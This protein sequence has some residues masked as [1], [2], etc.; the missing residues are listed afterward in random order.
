MLFN[1]HSFCVLY[2]ASLCSFLPRIS[3]TICHT[4]SDSRSFLI[5]ILPCCLSLSLLFQLHFLP[6]SPSITFY[7]LHL[8]SSITFA[9]HISYVLCRYIF[10]VFFCLLYLSPLV[11]I[12]LRTSL[13]L[14]HL[15][16]LLSFSIS[17]LLPALS[18][19]L[20]V[21][22]QLIP[23]SH[24]IHFSSSV[25][26][27]SMCTRS[28]WLSTLRCSPSLSHFIHLSSWPGS[29]INPASLYFL[30]FVLFCST[31]PLFMLSYCMY[32]KSVSETSISISRSGCLC[33]N[34]WDAHKP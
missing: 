33:C 27:H 31:F 29:L 2:V 25:S 24:L 21:C 22:P 23:P 28:F 16:H 32:L 4:N 26:F 15:F 9:S 8:T 19:T 13:L 1:M 3:F 17:S 30:P 14:I 12:H 20:S 6:L 5:H 10:Q 11:P 18:I 7:F 34:L